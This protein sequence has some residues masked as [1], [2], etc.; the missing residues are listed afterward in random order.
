MIASDGAGPPPQ[1]EEGP[2]LKIRAH[3]ASAKKETYAGEA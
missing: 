2:R 3:E 1:K